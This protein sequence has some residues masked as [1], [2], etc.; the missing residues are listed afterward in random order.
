M[1]EKTVDSEDENE[2]DDDIADCKNQH[3]PGRD[4][5][6]L[7]SVWSHRFQ[8]GPHGQEADNLPVN[9]STSH[10]EQVHMFR[11]WQIYLENVD[12]LLKVTHTPTLQPRIIEAAG[13]MANI[14]PSLEA[15]IFSI[16]C[17]SVLSLIEAECQD[18]FQ[19]SRKL[20]LGR[21]QTACHG[22]L[23]KCHAWRSGD[24]DGL[25]AIYLYLVR[26]LVIC[27]CYVEGITL[28]MSVLIQRL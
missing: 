26:I 18:L 21:Y 13:N 3:G 11:L 23:L 15:L 4:D 20:L 28:I 8:A 12:P 17:V 25:T 5:A 2:E 27:S 22:A 9:L 16:Y 14:S 19:S 1:T 7:E 10:P 6:V 24:G